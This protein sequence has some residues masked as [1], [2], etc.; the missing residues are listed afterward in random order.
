MVTK[1]SWDHLDMLTKDQIIVF[2]KEYYPFN[3]PSK[4]Q[5]AYHRWNDLMDSVSKMQ[6]ELREKSPTAEWARKADA[7]AVE[8]NSEKD[9]EK[10]MALLQKREKY[11]VKLSGFYKEDERLCNLWKKYND[12]YD[13][14]KKEED[15]SK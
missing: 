11:M 10:K 14:I 7:C 1:P 15:V 8:F 6:D 9:H 4:S 5:V 2:V 12:W 13:K 3:P